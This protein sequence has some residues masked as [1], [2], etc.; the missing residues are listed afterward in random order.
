MIIIPAA[1]LGRNPGHKVVSQWKRRPSFFLF[2]K[3]GIEK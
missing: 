2:F 3:K 1:P